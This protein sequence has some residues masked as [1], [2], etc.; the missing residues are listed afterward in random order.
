M[1]TAIQDVNELLCF[2]ETHPHDWEQILVAPPYGIKIKW[3]GTYCLLKYDFRNSDFSI[4][5]VCACR[6]IIISFD[7]THTPF[8]K[9]FSLAFT[10]FFNYGEKHA[11]EIDWNT[12]VVQEK[13][14][15]SL[16]QVWHSSNYD[17]DLDDNEWH[18]STSGTINAYHANAGNSGVTFGQ[19]FEQA[20]NMKQL[21]P[22]LDPGRCYI[23][24]LVSTKSR[25]ILDY[26]KTEAYFLTARD[27]T[28]C[29][30]I[31]LSEFQKNEFAKHGIK[32]PAE[33]SLS[34][35][36]SCINAA[37]ALKL[38]GEGF[39]VKDTDG[40]RIKIKSSDYIKAAHLFSGDVTTPLI[41]IWLTGES[42]EFLNYFPEFSKKYALIEKILTGYCDFY[43]KA[44]KAFKKKTFA[45]RKALANAIVKSDYTN[46]GLLFALYDGKTN[47]VR[48][49]LQK[50]STEKIQKTIINP[51]V[52]W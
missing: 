31:K 33:Y 20:V 43:E 15:G 46:K 42:S 22:T 27:T 12:A 34:D 44:V 38:Q 1:K 48:E 35:L 11:A 19:L 32:F 16:I 36:D 7:S 10:K 51:D 49:Y 26:D 13:I 29:V 14:D 39:V 3:D 45:D 41:N 4:P 25:V 52:V 17:K 30:E 37:E 23:F 18:I 40:N 50:A 9:I 6:G 8:P 47:A 5:L 2:I 28:S 24:E 21:M